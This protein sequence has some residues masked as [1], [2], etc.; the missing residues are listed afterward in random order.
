MANIQIEWAFNQCVLHVKMIGQIDDATFLQVDTFITQY[1]DNSD[2]P[3]V[4][5]IFDNSGVKNIPSIAVY[6]R[7]KFTSHLRLGWGL[8]H[9]DSNLTRFFLKTLGRVNSVYF[10]S[11]D[12]YNACLA[13]LQTIDSNLDLQQPMPASV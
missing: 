7:I 11:C 1:L 9:H 12:T 13:F 3:Q 8:S 4:H 5:V 6:K 10:Q 2:V